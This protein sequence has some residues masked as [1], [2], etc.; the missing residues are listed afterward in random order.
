MKSNNQV[1]IVWEKI[2]SNE[3]IDRPTARE[4]HIL[5]HL[6]DRNSYLIFGGISLTRF[7]DVFVLNMT[8]KKWSVRKPTGE[9]PKELSHCVGWYDSINI[10]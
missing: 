8:D 10:Y 9:I 2:D 1:T 5:V 4:G 6:C 7:S 3:S